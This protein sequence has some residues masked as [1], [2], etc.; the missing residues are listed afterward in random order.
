MVPCMDR[1]RD[2]LLQEFQFNTWVYICKL[3]SVIHKRKAKHLLWFVGRDRIVGTAT[4]YSKS[5]IPVGQDFL[6]S[7]RVVLGPIQPVV[8]WAPDLFPESKQAGHCV[9]NP[10]QS[11][12]KVKERV[13]L[14]L[15]FPSG[16]SWPVLGW[17]SPLPLPCFGLLRCLVLVPE[18]L[19][20]FCVVKTWNILGLSVCYLYLMFNFHLPE[21]LSFSWMVFVFYLLYK[22]KQ[23]SFM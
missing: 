12:P 20:T 8:Q 19:C 21:V 18:Y 23:S 5:G 22:A 15:Y 9:N 16:P 4:R 2:K 7:S 14:Y 13:E 6:H 17:S 1:F 3:A 11:S 10:P